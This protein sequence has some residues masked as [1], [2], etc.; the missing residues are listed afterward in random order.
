MNKPQQ[1][2]AEI[3]PFKAPQSYNR[4]ELKVQ[5]LIGVMYEYGYGV[6]PNIDEAVRWYSDAATKGLPEAQNSLGFLYSLGLGVERNAETAA[7]WLHR[8]ANQANHAAQTNLGILYTTGRGVDKD[9]KK[10]VELFS[11]A[12]RSG[13]PQ[14]QQ[15]LAQAYDEGWYGLN[16]DPVQAD[17]WGRKASC[18]R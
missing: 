15:L 17:Y 11:A 10:A 16:C 4:Q 6:E 5:Y 13:N 7:M 8:A 14:A 3:I 1:Q 12:A 9:Y 18:S 2:T